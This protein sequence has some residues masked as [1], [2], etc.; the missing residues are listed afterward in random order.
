MVRQCGN[1]PEHLKVLLF[2]ADSGTSE[3][4]DGHRLYRLK[5]YESSHGAAWAEIRNASRKIRLPGPGRHQAVNALALYA[6]LL[7][8][9]FEETAVLDALEKFHGVWRRFDWAGTNRNGVR[10]Y[11]DYAHNVEKI[12][13]CL[14]AGREVSEGRLIAIF[15]PHGF[16]PLGFMREELFQA[17]EENLTD[18]DRFILLP[19]YYAGGTSSFQPQSAEVAADWKSRGKKHYEYAA[20][21]ADAEEWVRTHARKGDVVLVMGARDNSLSFWAEELAK[22]SGTEEKT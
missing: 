4:E 14:K 19:V 2:T 13:S 16:A 15:Q 7:E 9:G 5:T 12:I 6:E 18:D 22:S 17:L 10:F 3:E 8:L 1:L 21:R 11:D 20:A